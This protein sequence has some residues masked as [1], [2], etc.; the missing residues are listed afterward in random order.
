M[1]E[2]LWRIRK[3][4]LEYL[5]GKYHNHLLGLTEESMKVSGKTVNNLVKESTTML[6]ARQ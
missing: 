3:K 2:S 4:G 6:K 5:N 1:R